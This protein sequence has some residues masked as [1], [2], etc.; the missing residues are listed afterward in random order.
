MKPVD[1]PSMSKALEMLE[2]EVEI[3]K[4]PPKPFL[5]SI[6]NHEQS[7][8]VV[9]IS[10]SNSMGTITLNGSPLHSIGAYYRM[11]GFRSHL[12]YA[13]KTFYQ[14]SGSGPIFYTI[15]SMNCEQSISDHNYIPIIPCNTTGYSSSSSP[16]YSYAIVGEYVSV[17]DMPYSCTISTYMVIQPLK[18]LPESIN[19]SMSDLQDYLLLGLQLSFLPHFCSSQCKMKGANLQLY[20]YG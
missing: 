5:W 7:M 3:L 10:S 17:V 19:L 11:N 13:W 6:E 4:M 1:H 12:P 9:P 16:T 18:A 8:V 20:S 2:G 15:L 14:G